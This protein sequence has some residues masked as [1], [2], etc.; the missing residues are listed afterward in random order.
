MQFNETTIFN[1]YAT[2]MITFKRFSSTDPCS[3]KQ[4]D[5]KSLYFQ[6]QTIMIVILRS[7][8]LFQS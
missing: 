1:Q 7:L 8:Y 3:F 6:Y 5:L 4:V 2:K